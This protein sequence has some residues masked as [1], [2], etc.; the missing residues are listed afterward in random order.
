MHVADSEKNLAD[1]KHSNIVTEPSIF[2]ESIE[3]L[4]SWA[5]LKYHIDE[6]VILECSFE[7]IDEGMVELCEYLF[8]EFDVFD[9]L[10]VDYVWFWYLFE[11]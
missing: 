11:C 4:S 10:E 2:T 8:L 7:G 5:K 6:G 1:I 3:E 9:L